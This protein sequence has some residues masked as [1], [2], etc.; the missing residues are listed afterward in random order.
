M[1]LGLLGKSKLG[2]VN[3]KHPREF[4]PHALHD[5]WEK[6][7]A[8]VLSWIINSIRKDLLSSVI[9][10]SNA[11]KVWTDMKERFD[12]VNG[13]GIH[14]LH[15]E[16]HTMSQGTTTVS[17]YFSRL[18][19]CWDE[20]DAIMSCPGCNCPKSKAYVH[21]FDYQRLLQF[22]T[23][24][25]DSYA[26]SRSQI[27]MMTPTPSINQ[28]YSM[29][30]S[31]KSQ[32]SLGKTSQFTA[33]VSDGVVFYNNKSNFKPGSGSSS[34]SYRSAYNESTSNSGAGYNYN[35]Y[36]YNRGGGGGSISG[37]STNSDFG[38]KLH[39]YPTNFKHNSKKK[40]S[41]TSGGGGDAHYAAG[42]YGS[43]DPSNS[44]SISTNR[45]LPNVAGQP[46]DS[47]AQVMNS[48][49][50]H[51]PNASGPYFIPEQYHQLIHL[52]DQGNDNNGTTLY[53]QSDSDNKDLYKSSCCY[54]LIRKQ[55]NSLGLA[56][57]HK[58]LCHA[59]IDT[60]KKLKCLDVLC[61]TDS[62]SEHCTVSKLLRDLGIIH[63][64]SCVYTLQQNGVVERKHRYIL[65]TTR[66]IRFQ[67]NVHLKFWGECVS[68]VVYLINRLPFF[69]KVP[70]EALHGH[71]PDLNHLRVFGCL[72]YVTCLRKSDKFS[73]RA[74]PAI[75]LGYSLTQKGY[76]MFNLHT[77][78]FIVSRD[79]V[80]KEDV[81]PFQHPLQQCSP[82]F[83]IT[84]APEHYHSS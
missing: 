52:I 12:K 65:D 76:L 15:K 39:G 48:Y 71:I 19:E 3:G 11:S 72:G 5:L 32:R 55:K 42:E 82:M 61:M 81:F 41:P 4:F 53:Q 49:H 83:S 9:Y 80:F 8:I 21:H 27:L 25:N 35:G 77:D 69:G 17:G 10:V 33:E 31:E 63:Q 30:I 59:L 13:L 16:I 37:V 68:T 57:W 60:L 73:P 67:A 43:S 7:N 36:I 45:G 22:L 24:L 84:Q 2:F 23:G 79:V 75:F 38:Y 47:S 34:T 46:G 58:R 28:A 62:D 6:C 74:A 40:F 56:L 14:F 29:L 78:S 18:R 70:F 44:V 1:R 64:S 66:A 26:Q 54:F 50:Q 20:F 51:G